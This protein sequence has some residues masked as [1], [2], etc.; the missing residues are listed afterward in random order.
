VT[1]HDVHVDQA[2][3]ALVPVRAEREP[4]WDD[5][6]RRAET[7]PALPA[8]SRWGRVALAVALAVGLLAVLAPAI[9]SA[10]RLLGLGGGEPSA[11][12]TATG[13]VADPG[14]N[15]GMVAA[16][17]RWN[18]EPG[19]STG[20][21]VTSRAADL[22]TNVGS[23]H[24]TLTAFPTTKDGV[25]CFHVLGA[26]TCGDLGKFP[27]H[28]WAAELWIRGSGGRLFGVAADDVV[29]VEVEIAGKQNEAILR[30]N[31][32]YFEMP[33]GSGG[34]EIRVISTL[35]DGSRHAFPGHF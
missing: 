23:A 2:L 6:A 5:V 29:R 24:D 10:G 34:A 22:L 26:G 17:E 21:P 13:T 28:I 25:V 31:G 9:G 33:P 11:L 7:V 27:S 4:A 12:R 16:V 15:Q 30:N 3:S 18:G 1:G 14:N 32:F 8:R 20:R 35:A 19:N